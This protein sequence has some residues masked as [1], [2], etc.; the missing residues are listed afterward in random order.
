MDKARKIVDQ[1]L[2]QEDVRAFIEKNPIPH[3]YCADCHAD[4]TRP[5]SVTRDYYSKTTGED[6]D[7]DIRIAGHYE[8]DYFQPE[9][10]EDP[11]FELTGYDL[12]DDSDWCANCGSRSIRF[13]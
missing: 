9:P 11:G 3:A 13:T 5:G 1:L 6:P 8:K 10:D 7:T 12:C 4:L 2:E